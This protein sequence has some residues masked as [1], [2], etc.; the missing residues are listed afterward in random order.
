MNRAATLLDHRRH[1]RPDVAEFRVVATRV[2]DGAGD[3]CEGDTSLRERL[4]Q[5]PGALDPHVAERAL[6]ALGGYQHEH[7][8][9]QVVTHPGGDQGVSA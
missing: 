8:R 6:L 9:R 3:R 4:G 5:A 1:E 2:D 7:R